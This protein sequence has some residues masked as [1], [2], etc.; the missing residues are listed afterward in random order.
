M[1]KDI[2][3]EIYQKNK[4]TTNKATGNFQHLWS[5]A[6]ENGVKQEL[7]LLYTTIRRK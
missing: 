5:Q 3:I 6:G 7:K 1:F 4:K 2:R